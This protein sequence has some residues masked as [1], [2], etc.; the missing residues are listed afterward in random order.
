MQVTVAG[1][2]QL[3][4]ARG[5]EMDRAETVTLFNDMCLLA[6]ATLIDPALSWTALDA[7]RVRGE[8]VNAGHRVSAELTFDESGDL[9]NFRSDDRYQNDGKVE[10]RLPWSTPVSGYRDLDGGRLF[11]AGDACWIENGREWVYGHFE[12][13]RIDYN[14]TAP[15]TP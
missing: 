9:V 4:N 15:P 12:L 10:R 11:H 8:F 7:S 13:Q 1:A 3:E 6:P 14:L 2:F 5:P